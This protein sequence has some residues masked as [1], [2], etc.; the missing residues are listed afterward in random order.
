MSQHPKEKERIQAM[1]EE[2]VKDATTG[3]TFTTG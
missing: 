2:F 1:H 3:L